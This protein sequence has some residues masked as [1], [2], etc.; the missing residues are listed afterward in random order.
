MVHLSKLE[1]PLDNQTFQCINSL[2]ILTVIDEV[3]HPYI[4]RGVGSP[5]F[6]NVQLHLKASD[7]LISPS[8]AVE[9]CGVGSS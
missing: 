3:S 5:P 8:D 1:E 7:L 6:C 2:Q 9:C 4:V